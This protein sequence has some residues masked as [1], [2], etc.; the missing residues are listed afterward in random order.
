M[1]QED[2]YL[3]GVSL[4]TSFLKYVYQLRVS[5]CIGVPEK[6]VGSNYSGTSIQHKSKQRKFRYYVNF[7]SSVFVIVG[8]HGMHVHCVSPYPPSLLTNLPP[9]PPQALWLALGPTNGFE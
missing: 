4:F 5:F 9:P 7:I 1:S 2:R 6:G 8:I 3:A